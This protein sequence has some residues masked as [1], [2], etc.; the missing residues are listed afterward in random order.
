MTVLKKALCKMGRH[1]GQWSHPGGRCE[2]VRICH[3]CGRREEETR[4]I[5]GQFSYVSP[6]QCGQTRRC[7]R[8]GFSEAR[9]RHEW[10]PWVYHDEQLNSGQVRACQRCHQTERTTYTMR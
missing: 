6:D 8:C 2:I 10:G 5:W 3:S 7:E 4:H 1:S 9:F